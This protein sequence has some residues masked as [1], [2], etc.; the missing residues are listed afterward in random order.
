MSHPSCF[1]DPTPVVG[2]AHVQDQAVHAQTTETLTRLRV[3]REPRFVERSE[4]G[5]E[6]VGWITARYCAG[7]FFA[8]EGPSIRKLTWAY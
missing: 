5:D 3:H 8:K 7:A 1:R 2:R 4:D 6:K